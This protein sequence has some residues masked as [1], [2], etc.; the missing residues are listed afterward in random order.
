MNPMS[1]KSMPKATFRIQGFDSLL[2]GA[3]AALSAAKTVAD[4]REAK[5][6]SARMILE[7]IK[8]DGNTIK[9][10]CKCLAEFDAVVPQQLGVVDCRIQQSG[11]ET[12]PQADRDSGGHE[13][14]RGKYSPAKKGR[15][16]IERKRISS[17]RIKVA[18]TIYLVDARLSSS[19]ITSEI[20]R[21]Y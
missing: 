19:G 13:R 1:C 21:R 15:S 20:Q 11:G 2:S 7:F 5:K 9:F 18:S 12:K 16:A 4:N 17:L 10:F 14:S 3:V 6:N 8:T